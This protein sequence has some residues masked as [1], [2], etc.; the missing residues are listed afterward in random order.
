MDDVVSNDTLPPL[1]R[2]PPEL[3]QRIWQYCLANGDAIS[4]PFKDKP[5]RNTTPAV[6]HLCRT[7]KSEAE[8]VLYESNVMFFKHPSDCNM[9]LYAHN[10]H[11]SRFTRRMLVHVGDRD[12]ALWTP[13]FSSTSP[14]RSLL[15]DY[16]NL[17]ELYVI[18]RASYPLSN[19][20][21]GIV[22]AYQK[23]LPNQILIGLCGSLQSRAESGL[24]VRILFVRLAVATDELILQER[25]PNDFDRYPRLAEGPRTRTRFTTL[26]GCKVALDATRENNPWYT[27]ELF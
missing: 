15:H 1:L 14:H 17:Q 4:W 22:E 26:L 18:V 7:I 12:L 25:Y 23:W 13:Y 6:L 2:L 9:F 8:R 19:N 5:A 21:H 3:R 27:G 11:L 10:E 24:R 20:Q 16:P